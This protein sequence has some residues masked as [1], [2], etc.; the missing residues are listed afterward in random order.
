MRELGK[1]INIRIHLCPSFYYILRIISQLILQFC[2]VFKREWKLFVKIILWTN[3]CAKLYIHIAQS[4][5]YAL[6]SLY[7]IYKKSAL[8][9]T[10]LFVFT[11]LFL[12]R[13]PNSR[14]TFVIRN[15]P[16]RDA[17]YRA[18]IPEQ[19]LHQHERWCRRPAWHCGCRPA[20]C[21]PHRSETL[22]PNSFG[23]VSKVVSKNK[24]T[25][26]ARESI[27]T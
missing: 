16:Q 19:E 8:S 18:N 23:V 27:S 17:C 22:R 10:S 9:Y 14:R 26:N 15:L 4:L 6:T 21:I 2:S 11:L 25:H 1:C 7:A 24:L 12:A 13:M 5:N 20:A 3:Q